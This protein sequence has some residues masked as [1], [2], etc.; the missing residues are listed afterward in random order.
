MVVTI[1][2]IRVNPVE[3]PAYTDNSSF[4]GAASNAA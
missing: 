4:T 2:A 3:R 1:P